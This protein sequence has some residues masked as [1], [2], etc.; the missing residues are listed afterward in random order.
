[1]NICAVA[2][3]EGRYVREWVEFHRLVGVEHFTIFDNE[4]T[5]DTAAILKKLDGVEVI[6]WPMPKPNQLAAYQ[7]YIDRHREPV[8]TAFIDLDEFLFSPQYDTIPEAL[9]M[10]QFNHPQVKTIGANWACFGASGEQ[11]YRPEP[12][13]E[14]FTHRLPTSNPA[15]THIKSIIW[16]DQEVHTGGDPHF[17]HAETGTW[18]ENGEP[19]D[20]PLFPHSSDILRINHYC[21]KSRQE[22]RARAELGTPDRVEIKIDEMDFEGYQNDV[23]E[24][25]D[26]QRFLPKLKEILNAPV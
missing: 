8:W 11:E 12:V 13:I 6:P 20:G 22:W 4:S 25:R 1:V 10:I 14:R 21:T 18:N 19:V 24:D 5:D 16:M 15:S 3:N 7:H 2:K 23:I 26:I 9:A 17:F